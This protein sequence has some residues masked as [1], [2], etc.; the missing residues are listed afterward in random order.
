MQVVE[1]KPSAVNPKLIVPFVNAV[2]HVLRTMASWETTVERPRVKSVAGPEYDYSGI[3]AFSGT[4]VGTVVVSFHR[5][6]AIKL[7]A[8]FTGCEMEPDTSD[9]ADALGELTNLIVG[10]AKTELG[11]NASISVPT[12]IMGKGHIVSRPSDIPCIVVPCKTA[13][14]EFA[15]EV[16]IK[17]S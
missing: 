5:D 2:R 6:L 17:E 4:L 13:A 12:V 16:S 11:V 8:A 14:G 7:V 1:K 9:F 15:V 3:I 10:A